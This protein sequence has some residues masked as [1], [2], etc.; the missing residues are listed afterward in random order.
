MSPPSAETLFPVLDYSSINT[1]A[2]LGRGN[3]SGASSSSSSSSSGV[4][5]GSGPNNEMVMISRSDLSY[6]AVSVLLLER[7][8]VSESTASESL[9]SYTGLGRLE[10]L[11]Q[12]SEQY[13]VTARL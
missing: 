6:R 9:T 5:V 4:G 13:S 10:G 3:T 8:R 12:S 1:P 11:R 2:A 7:D